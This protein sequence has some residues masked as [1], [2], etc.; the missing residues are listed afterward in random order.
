[1]MPHAPTTRLIPGGRLDIQIARA[2]IPLDT[3]LA[4]AARRKPRR[5]FHFLSRIVGR[6]VATRPSDLRDAAAA[7]ARKLVCA[8]GPCL[9]VGMA[10]TATTLGQAVWREWLLQGGEDSLYLDT[11][12]RATDG[13]VAFAFREDHSHAPV[14]LVHRPPPAND[15]NQIFTRAASLIIVDDEATTARTA[16]ALVDA[17]A[18]WRGFRP[19]VTLLTLVHWKNGA[20][21]PF[22]CYSLI[23]GDFQ[24]TPTA[25]PAEVLPHTS[26]RQPCVPM[27]HGTRHGIRSPQVLPWTAAAAGKILVI[28]VGEFGF[29][30]FLLAEQTERSGAS[31]LVQATTR[32]PLV[33]GGA[34]HHVRAFP[35]IDGSDYTEFLYNVGDDH[36]YD[37]VILCCEGSPPPTTH[38]IRAVPRLEVLST[39]E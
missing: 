34:I 18:E 11:S 22:N 10:E 25:A 4:F 20:S 38:P 21:L 30:P 27:H 19:E 2:D 35:A 8:P 23:E 15:P 1:M 24:F 29:M 17:Y 14:H 9:F 36:P 28:G 33:E 16:S 3:A 26:H 31:A 39:H 6:H 13:Q 12:R 5:Q 37:R 7:L 32:S